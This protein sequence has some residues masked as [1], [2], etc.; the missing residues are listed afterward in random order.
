MTFKKN[1]G[2]AK[3][4][5]R[6]VCGGT[7]D[8]FEAR[9]EFQAGSSKCCD[10]YE[11]FTLMRNELDDVNDASA[12]TVNSAYTIYEPVKKI[13]QLFTSQARD[14]IARAFNC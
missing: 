14:S 12:R 13:C 1:N 2:L 3:G 5:G 8:R 9:C 10:P 11:F 4:A 6:L 7:F